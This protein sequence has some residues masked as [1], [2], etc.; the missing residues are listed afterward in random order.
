MVPISQEAWNGRVS[1]SILR[2]DGAVVTLI[3]GAAPHTP[4]AQHA[5]SSL[6]IGSTLPCPFAFSA[7]TSFICH[8][9]EWHGLI[10]EP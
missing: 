3:L 2:K 9:D 7:T 1:S 10:M 8:D 5:T 4:P 6:G